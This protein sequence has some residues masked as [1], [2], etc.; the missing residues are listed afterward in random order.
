MMLL[1]TYKIEAISSILL[2]QHDYSTSIID[3]QVYNTNIARIIPLC[4]NLYVYIFLIHSGCYTDR[5]IDKCT[6][7]FT[8]I[9]LVANNIL[10]MYTLSTCLLLYSVLYLLVLQWVIKS[11]STSPVKDHLVHGGGE[12]VMIMTLVSKFKIVLHFYSPLNFEVQQS[13][14]YATNFM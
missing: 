12:E 1:T 11:Y 2:V 7:T 10:D 5:S 14:S 13:E 8:C 4:S 6:Y 3:R 9:V